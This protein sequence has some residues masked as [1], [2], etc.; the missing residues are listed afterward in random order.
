MHSH[1]LQTTLGCKQQI[2]VNMLSWRLTISLNMDLSSHRIKV[3][4]NKLFFIKFGCF[5][6]FL[7]CVEQ[8]R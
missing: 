6:D 1:I 8:I 7:G 4:R 2:N 5:S 3:K